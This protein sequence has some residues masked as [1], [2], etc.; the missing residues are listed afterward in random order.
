MATGSGMPALLSEKRSSQSGTYA[1]TA[2]WQTVY[3]ESCTQA[4][5]FIAGLIDLTNM[6]AG[7]TINVQVHKILLS[8]GAW[9]IHDYMSYSNAQPANHLIC[10][11][12]G[13][14]DVYGLRIQMQQTAVAAALL[15]IN[16]E[17]HDAKRLGMT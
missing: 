17:F 14:P 16:C 15:N 4:Y 5:F 12:A 2:A 6:A 9:V 3:T 1:M 8:G 13:I 7:D 10:A 11:I